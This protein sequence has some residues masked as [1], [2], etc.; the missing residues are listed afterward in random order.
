VI[1]INGK[2]Q[3]Y[4]K[5]TLQELLAELELATSVCAIEVNNTLVPFDERSDCKLQDGD[6]VEIVS[7][8]GGG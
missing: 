1:T 2:K 3:I 7:L 5:L 6:R 4:K 8:V